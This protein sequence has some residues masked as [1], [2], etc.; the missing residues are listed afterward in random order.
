MNLPDRLHPYEAHFVAAATKTGLDPAL[1]A[2]ICDRE[3]LGGTAKGYTPKGPAGR[4][5]GGHGHGLMQID[6]RYHAKFIATGNWSRADAN[7]LYAAELLAS[8]IRRFHD[9]DPPGAVFC[10]VAA[11]NC[12]CTR[13]ERVLRTYREVPGGPSIEE[14]ID[15]RTTGGNYAR[16]VLARRARFT[17]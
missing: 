5:D 1:L 17:V 10:A 9:A 8:N 14:A 6:D 7:I 3:T 13:V 11:Y 16:D 4:G 2:A 15:A 12:G